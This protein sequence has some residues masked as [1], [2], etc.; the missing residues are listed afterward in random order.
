MPIE[1]TSWRW[2]TVAD[3]DPWASESSGSCSLS[4]RRRRSVRHCRMQMQQQHAASIKMARRTTPCAPTG[5]TFL[6]VACAVDVAAGGMALALSESLQSVDCLL[7]RHHG[8]SAEKTRW[9][10]DR[11]HER[12][13]TVNF[14]PN[15][16]HARFANLRTTHTFTYTP[17]PNTGSTPRR[18]HP[19]RDAHKQPSRKGHTESRHR[20][21]DLSPRSRTA[22][23]TPRS[24]RAEVSPPQSM[25]HDSVDGGI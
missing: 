21:D 23:Q 20:P 1:A 15:T 18:S 25:S 13:F 3:G 10:A 5:A 19:D 7:Q 11:F 17:G 24:A 8:L 6:G 22:R 12:S 4:S 14:R 9:A 2:R 16:S